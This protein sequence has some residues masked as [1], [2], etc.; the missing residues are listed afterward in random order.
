METDILFK[1]MPSNALEQHLHVLQRADGHTGLADITHY[2]LIVGVVAAMRGQ[3]EGHGQAL[4]TTGQV[5]AIESVGF[6]GRR[7]SGILTDGPRAES[8]HHGVRATQIGRYA[9][10]IIQVL[11]PFQVF[12]GIN[13]LHFNVLRRLPVSVDA[14]G[15]LP[16]SA[17]DGLESGIYI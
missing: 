13:R 8:V 11:H 3:V 7:E 4:L 5:A 14:V 10:G 15:L 6:L 16:L 9:G 12:L 2:A 17:V 1:G